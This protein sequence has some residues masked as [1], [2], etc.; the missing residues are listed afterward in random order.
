M[1]T[2]KVIFRTWDVREYVVHARDE[3][4]AVD[5]AEQD[6][7]LELRDNEEFECIDVLIMDDKEDYEDQDR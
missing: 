1:A 2:F 5:E 4:K 6:L 7:F 3:D